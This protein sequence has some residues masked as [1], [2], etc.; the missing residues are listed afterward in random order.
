MDTL[1]IFLMTKNEHSI[2]ESWIKYHG[3]IFGLQNIF[4]LDGS[5]DTRVFR[6]Y[7]KYQKQGLT[8]QK[9]STGLDGLSGELTEMM[10]RYKTDNSFLI[11]LDTD[12]FL[13]YIPSKWLFLFY[14]KNKLWSFISRYV[15][16]NFGLQIK[17]FEH[18]FEKLPVNGQKYKASLTCWSIP[19]AEDPVNI[20]K[21]IV[22]FTPL[23]QTDFKS[24]FH[25]S[26]FVSVD[27]GCHSGES[28]KND[29]YINTG[30]SIIH[31]HSTSVKDSLRRAKQ[32]L[33]SH[34]YISSGDSVGEQYQ[35][36]LALRA[37]GEIN[38][39][40][41]IDLFLKYLESDKSGKVLDA[42]LLNK[43][44]PFFKQVSGPRKMT[45]VRDVLTLLN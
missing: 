21:D 45:L 12:E 4:V 9:T 13:A 39:F 43:F 18:F 3:S 44:H 7:E 10:H 29:G 11:K 23:H 19:K 16:S 27:L 5:D 33:L 40:H 28:T 34:N 6:I 22:Y 1:K 26:S 32:V 31:Y 20:C 14:L 8:V 25:S 37:Q 41:K 24:F 15:L 17:N 42:T 35:K 30:L 38:S 2:L 36:L